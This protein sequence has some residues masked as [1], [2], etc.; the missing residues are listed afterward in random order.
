MYPGRAQCVPAE[1]FGGIDRR[2]FVAEH[3][4]NC[5]QFGD[6]ADRRARTVGVDVIHIALQALQ[7]HA[8]GARSAFARGRHHVVAVRGCGVTGQFRVDAGAAGF[9]VFE[10]LDYQG[11]AASADDEAV[12]VPVERARGCFGM[13]VEIRGQGAHGVEHVGEGPV[14][15]FAAAGEDQVLLV[16]LDQFGGMADAMGAGRAGGRYRIIDALDAEGG[17]EAGGYRTAH[18][19]RHAIGADAANAALAHDVEGIELILGR[20][21]AGTHHEAD[22]LAGN[23]ADLKPGVGNGLFH[24]D[25]AVGRAFAHEA[26]KLAVDPFLQIDVDARADLRAHAHFRIFGVESDAAAAFPQGLQH[27]ILVVAQAGNDSDPGHYDASHMFLVNWSLL[28]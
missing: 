26:Q 9:G 12:A 21:A 8:H 14:L 17:G 24:G 2:N 22:P 19:A 1:G 7:G 13:I 3:L 20:A 25:M 27:R 15:F 10:F 28:E 11:T 16:Q 23:L 18:G 6:I 5:G 4:A